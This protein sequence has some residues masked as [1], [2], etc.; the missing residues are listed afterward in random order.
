MPPLELLADGLVLGVADVDR[1]AAPAL[2]REGID[3][4]AYP[5]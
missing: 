4:D 5:L 1:A 3:V 2:L